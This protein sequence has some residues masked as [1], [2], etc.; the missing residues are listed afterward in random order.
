MSASNRIL[1]V[2]YGT[3]SCTLEGFDDPFNTMQSIAEYFRG[4][5]SEDRYFGAEP[6]Q[7]D[8]QMLHRIAEREINRRVEAH[9]AETGVVLRQLAADS[10]APETPE[11]AAPLAPPSDG[12][13]D[14][15]TDKLNR[16]R[17]AVAR[18]KA[19]RARSFEEDEQVEDAILSDTVDAAFARDDA[20][21][22]MIEDAADFT[23]DAD[24]DDE[25]EPAT[26]LSEAIAAPDDG[27]DE[28][29]DDAVRDDARDAEPALREA[30]ELAVPAASLAVGEG[31]E[32]LMADGLSLD[33]ADRAEP[34]DPVAEPQKD[35][36]DAP[37][38]EWTDTAQDIPLVTL[39]E[40]DTA[41]ESDAPAEDRAEDAAPETEDLLI[42]RL[43]ADEAEGETQTDASAESDSTP[44][45][46][47][48]VAVAAAGDEPADADSDEDIA[49]LAEMDGAA[50]DAD[51]AEE[52]GTAE[53][54]DTA[55]EDD[56]GIEIEVEEDGE[57]RIVRMTRA[58][59]DAAVAAGELEEVT[60][61]DED[62]DAPGDDDAPVAVSDDEGTD[63]VSDRIRA[64][65]AASS[66]SDEA[67][68]EL[69][70]ELSQAR[71]AD[72]TDEGVVVDSDAADTPEGEADAP[73]D[74]DTPADETPA[75]PVAKPAASPV[76]RIL[77]RTNAELGDEE[78]SRR[79]NAI[80]HLKRAVAATRADSH[81]ESRQREDAATMDRFREDLNDVVRPRRPVR[82]GGASDRRP[83][84]SVAPLVLV[85]AQRV[86]A[87]RDTKAAEAPVRPRR[88]ASA[89]APERA[90]DAPA[91]DAFA[92][93]RGAQDMPEMLEA[94]AAYAM[95]VEGEE[96]Q[97]R[98]ELM[99]R[100]A[101]AL[102]GQISR[103][104]GLRSFGIL[105]RQGRL[106]KLPSGRFALP[107]GADRPQRR[108]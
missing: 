26:T 56:D 84:G 92:R 76:D 105:L 66:L 89:P 23:R 68:T 7:P 33:P 31:A 108:A 104:E 59:F 27:P 38:A 70:S 29:D 60:G 51:T 83:G 41:E 2:S 73:R 35:E 58:E 45:P 65:L 47:D 75:R 32:A 49:A 91:F 43:L 20:A 90:A 52:E 95:I 13:T 28:A 54:G 18:A 103:E 80:A 77:D 16:I 1:T 10:P 3:F 22:D 44:E 8:P 39:P 98:P 48:E 78:S 102:G 21:P 46:E 53:E 63:P 6:P 37:E 72:R 99:K 40:E 57:I 12:A 106:R 25:S 71:S 19:E 74:A 24:V 64:M 5:A 14:S 86:D 107:E 101:A 4:L 87:G 93:E 97:S 88:I 50:P 11:T 67:R 85:S 94:A 61:A 62:E 69:L 9:V 34:V 15:V 82:D 100:A 55:D 79:R 17:E 81:A 30:P 96:G 36:Q 42:A